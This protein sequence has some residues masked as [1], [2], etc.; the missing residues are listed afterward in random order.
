V[1][2]AR[3]ATLQGCPPIGSAWQLSI[4]DSASTRSTGRGR[5]PPSLSRRTGSTVAARAERVSGRSESSVAGGRWDKNTEKSW[6]QHWESQPGCRSEVGAAGRRCALSRRFRPFVGRSLSAPHTAVRS[7]RLA[8]VDRRS[9][10]IPRRGRRVRWR[11]NVRR[12]GPDIGYRRLG[13]VANCAECSGRVGGSR[14]RQC[15]LRLL[16]RQLR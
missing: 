15:L 10:L 5:R 8:G 3:C 2:A 4:R 11:R 6:A 7:S 9:A 1:S 16:E 14:G 13:Q 12:A